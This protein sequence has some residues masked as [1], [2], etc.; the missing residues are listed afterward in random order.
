MCSRLQTP[1]ASREQP[2]DCVACGGRPGSR[3]DR[4]RGQLGGTGTSCR[5][6]ALRTGR[7]RPT[8]V[9]AQSELIAVGVIS[10]A[11]DAGLRVPEDLS[12]VGFDGITVEDS[13]LHRRPIRRLTIP[14]QPLVQTSQ[15][16][17]RTA[18]AMLEGPEPQP[19][20]FTSELR[21]G[22]TTGPPPAPG[23]Y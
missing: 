2:N 13:P 20:S 3:R 15:A 5:Q 19:A 9:I 14:A 22:D 16:A 17:A 23:T 11:I 4:D 8:A 12:V 21:V 18:L 10:A 1:C 7:P 6:R